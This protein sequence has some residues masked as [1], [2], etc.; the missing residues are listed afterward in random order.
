GVPAAELADTLVPLEDVL[1]PLGS[2]LLDR[3]HAAATWDARF[4]ALDEVLGRAMER[5]PRSHALAVRPEVAET[6]RRLVAARGLV[7][8]GAV[9]SE[10][11]WSRRH[12][13][14]RFRIEM[15][16]T[17][18]AVARILRFEHAYG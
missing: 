6:W 14:E 11:G 18:K 2:E 4:A 5:A 16:L 9:A 7:R 10:L 8:V 3:M 17:P 13:A 12:L 1:G 15:G